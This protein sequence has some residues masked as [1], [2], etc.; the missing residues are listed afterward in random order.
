MKLP[1]E[2][3]QSLHQELVTVEM[4]GLFDLR[5]LRVI[6]DESTGAGTEEASNRLKRCR[7]EI[8]EAIWNSRADVAFHIRDKLLETK[9]A[10]Q[11]FRLFPK[12][13]N[14]HAYI[15]RQ[16]GCDHTQN[17]ATKLRERGSI[18]GNR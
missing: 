10:L 13:M 1:C 3:H 11:P 7:D 2:H 16:H 17:D 12:A 14:Q 15:D 6:D 4:I 18:C 9:A 8:W 5:T